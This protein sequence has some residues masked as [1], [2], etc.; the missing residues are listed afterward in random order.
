MGVDLWMLVN[1]PDSINLSVAVEMTKMNM[2]FIFANLE[3]YNNRSC[4]KKNSRGIYHLLKFGYYMYRYP[5][6]K[7]ACIK[8]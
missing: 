5:V 2:V 6:K 1:D 7:V 8:F 3:N 4:T